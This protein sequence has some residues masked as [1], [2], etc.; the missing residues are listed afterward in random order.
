MTRAP[1]GQH[2]TLHHANFLTLVASIMIAT[3]LSFYFLYCRSPSDAEDVSISLI[4]TTL[5]SSILCL[6][7]AAVAWLAL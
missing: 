1:K 7:L 4:T 2:H 3:G 6:V 5:V